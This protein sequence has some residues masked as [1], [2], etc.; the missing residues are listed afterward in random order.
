MIIRSVM[1]LAFTLMSIVMV[2]MGWEHINHGYGLNPWIAFPLAIVFYI[3]PNRI[4]LNEAQ[5]R[6][7]EIEK[8]KE[9]I[10]T[11]RNN[12]IPT[13]HL[14]DTLQWNI[15]DWER[16]LAKLRAAG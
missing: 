14:E 10:S 1:L 2:F 16:W 7:Y 11:L 9:T 6:D 8:L 13:A 4:L 3:Y 5:D 12:F 15:E